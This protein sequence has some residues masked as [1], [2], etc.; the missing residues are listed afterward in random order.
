VVAGQWTLV[1]VVLMALAALAVGIQA[2][3]HAL[4]RHQSA[5]PRSRA[6][7]HDDPS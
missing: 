5:A 2:A 6:G 1:D 4:K 3:T 7:I